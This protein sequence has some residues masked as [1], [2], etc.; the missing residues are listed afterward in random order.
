MPPTAW[1]FERVVPSVEHAGG[2]GVGLWIVRQLTEAMKGSI[3]VTSTPVAGSTFCVNL[4]LMPV[5][6]HE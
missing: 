4:P 6:E 2:F 5:K 1:R 3:A